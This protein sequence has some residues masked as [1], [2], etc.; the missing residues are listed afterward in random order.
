MIKYT[1]LDGEA[2]FGDRIVFNPVEVQIGIVNLMP[3]TGEIMAYDRGNLTTIDFPG[4]YDI[5]DLMIKVFA[6]KGDKLNFLVIDDKIS[7]GIIQSP[8]VLELDDV[9]G[10]DLRFFFDET[11][12]KKLDQLEMEGEKI[13]LNQIEKAE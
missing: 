8:E 6:G 13:N 11:V 7:F 10:M 12:S 5:D 4:E 1:Y 2:R 9:E 3:I